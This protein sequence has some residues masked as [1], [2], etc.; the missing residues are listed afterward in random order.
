M[1]WVNRNFSLDE[2]YDVDVI[3]E[4]GLENAYY[5]DDDMIIIST[6]QNREMRLYSLLHEVGHVASRPEGVVMQEANKKRFTWEEKVNILK[7]EYRAWEEGEK[8]AAEMCFGIDTIKYKKL[9]TKCLKDYIK[10]ASK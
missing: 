10:W 6:K 3:Y 1:V 8:L 4:N 9:A 7:E 5:P 2:F